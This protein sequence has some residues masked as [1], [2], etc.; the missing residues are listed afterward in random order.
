M[1]GET[2]RRFE[3]KRGAVE[4]KAFGFG[5][6]LARDDVNLRCFGPARKLLST[7]TAS[8]CDRAYD[9]AYQRFREAIN[10]TSHTSDD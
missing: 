8:I 4:K 2:V 5:G 3:C 9:H 1:F 10:G 6:L 7:L